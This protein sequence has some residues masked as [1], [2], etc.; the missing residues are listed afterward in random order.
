MTD[1]QT[2]VTTF[3][4]IQILCYRTTLI[5]RKHD[6]PKLNMKSWSS[7]LFDQSTIV[8]YDELSNV[9]NAFSNFA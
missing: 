5:V 3:I 2:D 1:R 9:A 8:L 4:F 7:A 6:G